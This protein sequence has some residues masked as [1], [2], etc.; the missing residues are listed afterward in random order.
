MPN[1]EAASIKEFASARKTAK[2]LS[3]I[4][5]GGFS[6]V[7]IRK[8]MQ[9]IPRDSVS[10]THLDPPQ[11]GA[12]AF[13][14]P[15]PTDTNTLIS[16]NELKDS[17]VRNTG[18]GSRTGPLIDSTRR[19]TK[20]EVGFITKKRLTALSRAMVTGLTLTCKW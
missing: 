13:K 14:T 5:I 7:F 12:T 2:A 3:F 8:R 15:H 9:P 20:E 19:E 11:V 18:T 4:V 10:G 17:T 6:D 16:G 1:A